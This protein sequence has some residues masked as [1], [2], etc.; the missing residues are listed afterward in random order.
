[1]SKTEKVMRRAG[2]PPRRWPHIYEL[3]SI[4]L[5]LLPE[6]EARA[7][8]ENFSAML[9]ALTAP[10]EI[11]V[12]EDRRAVALGDELYEIP[13][14]RFFM[15]SEEP[16]E[17]ALSLAGL[18]FVKV[19]D[20]PELKLTADAPRFAVDADGQFVRVYTLIGLTPA[21]GAGWLTDLYPYLHEVR[22]HL[23]PLENGRDLAVHHYRALAA[24]VEVRAREGRPVDPE[25]AMELEAAR[26][27]SDAVASGREQLFLVRTL[28]VIRARD[29]AEMEQKR[30]N[31][32]ARLHGFIDSPLHMNASMYLGIGP[33]WARGR[34]LYMPT[35]TLVGF[36]PFAGLDLIDPTPTAIVLGQNL[37]TGNVIAYDVYERENYNVAIFGQTGY[38][39]STLVKA[40]VSRFAAADP[41]A[42]IWVFDSIVRPEY[43][44]GPG[45][46]YEGS[47]AELIGAEVLDLSQP[48]AM[49]PLQVFE[50]R[51]AALSFIADLAG[52]TEP[53]LRADLNLLKSGHIE[54][55]PAEAGGPLGKR[56]EA[57]LRPFSHLW[58]GKEST[59]TTRQVFVLSSIE[60]AAVRDAAAYLALA[61]VWKNVKKS[62]VRTRKMIVVDEGWAFVEVNPKTG[63][64]YFP[65]TVEFVPEV[66]R[67]GRHY[68]AAFM[69]AT[70]RV[71]DMMQG[72]GRVV[73]EN[74]ATKIVLHQDAAAAEMLAGPLALSREEVQFAVGARIGQALLASPEGHVPLYVMLSK[75]ELARF[76]T[77][78]AEVAA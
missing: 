63:K 20:M 39:K 55:L 58:S 48:Q 60:G 57:G 40:W 71:S 67:T 11:R 4:N 33:E 6:Q 13:Y 29:A 78:P 47:F 43:A 23:R 70:Q 72:P 26:A 14:K 38:G 31:V 24:A 45:G 41:D 17:D 18:R 12:V 32:R 74:A 5:S 44:W 35:S 68:N 2:A 21:M 69:I 52:I 19:P 7:V 16:L 15:A 46:T 10:A 54:D 75:S 1:M 25:R 42:F 77:K 65:G 28:L 51:P 22:I 64:P 76:T 49:D 73:L 30:R 37:L 56:L 50:S 61:W 3:R 9:N 34:E 8:L 62:P 27:A 66:A 36:F 53:D 59:L